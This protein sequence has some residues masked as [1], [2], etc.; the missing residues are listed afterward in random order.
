V[1][2]IVRH[3]NKGFTLS[4]VLVASIILTIGMLGILQTMVFSM[5][6][7]LYNFSRD[8]SVRISAQKM[9]E[10]RNTSFGSLASGSSIVSRTYKQYSRT[11]NL[12][13]TVTALSSNSYA[14]QIVVGWNISGKGYSHS[15]TSLISRGT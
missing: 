7:N 15:I 14:V 3:N 9:N 10:L 5:Q 13:W 1:K 4:E 12:T 8:E 6:Q 2:L 11:F